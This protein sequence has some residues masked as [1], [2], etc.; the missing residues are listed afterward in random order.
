MVTSLAPWI[1]FNIFILVMLA[2]DLF[3]HRRTRVIGM[4]EALGWSTIWISL[5]MFFN[6]GIY[7][8]LGPEASLSFFTG[9][10]IEKSLS[11]DNLFVF[12]L[13]FTYF[14]TP[15]HLQHKVL[16]WGILGAIIMRAVFIA[17]GISLINYFEQVL[18]IFAVFLIYAGIKM[19]FKDDEEMAP[20]HNPV[21]KLI[22]RF[23]PITHDYMGHKFFVH[24][25]KKLWATPLFVVL[26][27]IETT[28]VIFA[29]DSI[30]A[31]LAITQDPFIVYTSNIF[32]ILGLRSLFFALSGLMQLFHYLQYAL[33]FI[34]VFIGFKMLLAHWVDIPT[35]IALGVTLF[36][37]MSAIVCSLLYPTKTK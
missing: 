14:K 36:S 10:L 1:Y 35:T 28:D 33:A 32:A 13:I 26:M 24:I 15:S 17:V 27:S 20:H 25:D 29:L 2:L 7:V 4:R 8:Y 9:Y 21:L 19:A 34:L 37:L 18:Y 5:A 22:K 11:V 23:F 12:I 6:L 16:F 3:A 30:P 31:I